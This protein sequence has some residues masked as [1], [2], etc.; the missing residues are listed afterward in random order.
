[1]LQHL[2]KFMVGKLIGIYAGTR[3]GEGKVPVESAELV[4]D[5]GLRG[6]NHAGRDPKRQ[7]SLFAGEVLHELRSEGFSVS[8][9]QLSANLLTENIKLNSLE[10]GTQIRIGETVIE[11]V[12]ARKPCRNLT[13]IDN[14]LP[15]RLYGHCGQLGRIVKGGIVRAGDEI[16]VIVEEK[17]FHL[18]EQH[19]Q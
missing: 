4:A 19:L 3:K 6:D 2:H 7:V 10:P 13:R 17:Q 1:M 15:K 18:W 8:A 14:R 16:E 11:V 5:H 9:E 12:E